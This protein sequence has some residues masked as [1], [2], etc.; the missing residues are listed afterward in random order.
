MPYEF[1]PRPRNERLPMEYYCD[2]ERVVFLTV[3][4]TEHSAPFATVRRLLESAEGERPSPDMFETTFNHPLCRLVLDLLQEAKETCG[5]YV[6][7]A[8]LM[9]DHMHWLARPRTTQ[10][11]G[12][13]ARPVQ[14]Q[15]HK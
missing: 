13:D 7:A 14:G 2:P 11:K 1:F 15:E 10:A 5:C 3:R 9:P 4:A 12:D 6:L 8:C